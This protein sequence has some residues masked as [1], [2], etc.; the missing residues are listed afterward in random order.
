MVDLAH[1]PAKAAT[2]GFTYRLHAE[3][4]I[5][6]LVSHCPLLLKTAW[7]PDGDKLGLLLQYRLNP[8]THLPKPVTLK[9]FFIV[10][11]YEGAR[12]S[13]VQTKPAGTHLKDKHLVYW[14]LGDVTFQ[15]GSEWN[16]IVCRI[17]GA[18][19]AEPKPG[20]VEA[21]WEYISSPGEVAGSSGGISI[22]RRVEGKGKGKAVDTDED[23]EDDPFADD[24]AVVSP[25]IKDDGSTW[26]EVPLVRKVVSGRYEAK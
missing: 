3:E 7:K 20:H 21:R 9:N 2:P 17:I 4:P 19:N 5:S 13:G 25:K 18:E 22:S 12:S 16:K 6:D 11:T 1:I 26:T 23:E 10:T 24:S 14:R 8:D 15:E